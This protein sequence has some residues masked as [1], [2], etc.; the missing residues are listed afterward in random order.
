MQTKNELVI[1]YVTRERILFV[2]LENEVFF[3]EITLIMT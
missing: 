2:K 1:I 3:L